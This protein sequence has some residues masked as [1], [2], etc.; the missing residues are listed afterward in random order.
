MQIVLIYVAPFILTY[1]LLF[2]FCVVTMAGA[3]YILGLVVLI[4]YGAFD[5]TL[6]IYVLR[7]KIKEKI[8]Y[9]SVDYH[10][11]QMTLYSK[12]Y[13]RAKKKRNNFY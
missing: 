4:F 11:Y 9:I 10:V 3:I 2:I 7:I 13:I 5:L 12:T 6:I 1:T 8:D